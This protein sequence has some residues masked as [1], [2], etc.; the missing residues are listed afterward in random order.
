MILPLEPDLL[1]EKDIHG[2]VRELRHL[3]T[4]FEGEPGHS[5]RR[6]A[7]EYLRLAAAK[8]LVPV[9]PDDLQ[10]LMDTIDSDK[11]AR[12]GKAGFRWS[13]SRELKRGDRIETTIVWCQQTVAVRDSS[14]AVDLHGSSIRLVVHYGANNRLLGTSAPMTTL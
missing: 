1:I 7:V 6:A 9:T 5:P 8:G 4:P 12:S 14:V 2:V 13:P 10:H 3:Q 11:P